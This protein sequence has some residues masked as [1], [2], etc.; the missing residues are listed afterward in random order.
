MCGISWYM[1]P[2]SFF[3]NYSD[4]IAESTA[5]RNDI[6]VADNI[7]ETEKEGSDSMVQ[8]DQTQLLKDDIKQSVPFVVQAPHAQWD[9]ERY[10]DACEEASLLMAHAWIENDGYISKND[11][12]E[13]LEKMF[14]QEQIL[15]GGATDTSVAD[16]AQFFTEY[17]GHDVY[18]H[19]NITME[20]MYQNL[21]D[22]AIIIAPTDGTKLGNPNFTNGGP[23]RHMLVIIGYDQKNKEFITNDPG[24]RVG[25]GYKYKDATLYNAIRDYKT[26]H[27]EPIESTSKNVIIIKK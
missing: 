24:T 15:F 27:K 9:D 25:R 18:V 10:Q 13:E 17:Y 7:K 11:A 14:A 12:E 26:G 19:E 23:E 5:Q 6:V 16:T 4:A 1:I 3:V 22:G 21:S 8:Q 2:D 20:A